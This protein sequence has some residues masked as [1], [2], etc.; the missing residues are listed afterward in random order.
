M[1]F[2]QQYNFEYLYLSSILPGD[3]GEPLD[4]QGAESS[5][6]GPPAM[7]E[8]AFS[9]PLQSKN[10]AVRL[11]GR[12]L[13]VTDL[14][15]GSDDISGQVLGQVLIKRV[16]IELQV[17]SGFAQPK[18]VEPVISDEGSIEIFRRFGSWKPQWAI[19]NCL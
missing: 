10:L 1:V 4:S 14:R 13:H 15:P 7:D 12:G 18:R 17:L 6:H 8:L 9:E 16:I 3:T 2:I 19:W 5:E 11:E